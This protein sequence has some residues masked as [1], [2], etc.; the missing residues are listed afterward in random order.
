[1]YIFE[2]LKSFEQGYRAA[3]EWENA[4]DSIKWVTDYLI[5]CHTGPNEFYGQVA[6]GGVD[7]SYWGR[8]EGMSTDICRILRKFNNDFPVKTHKNRL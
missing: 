1:M 2:P 6:N 3:G 7:H 8:P 4:V 5:R